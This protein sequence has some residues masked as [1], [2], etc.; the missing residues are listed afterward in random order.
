M[1]VWGDGME[2]IEKLLGKILESQE[3]FEEG[4]KSMQNE[5]SSIKGELADVK[6]EVSGIKV[7]LADVKEEVSGIKVELA[8]VKEE[9]SGI[10]GELADVKEEVS[11]IKGEIVGMKVEI[12]KVGV[13]QEKMQKDIELLAEGHKNIIEIM[14]RKFDDMSKEVN[15]RLDE[16]EAAVTNLGEDVKFIKHKEFQNEESIFKLKESLKIAK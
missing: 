12:T 15:N 6:E 8:D 5:I 11:G 7:E 4:Q 16:V 14:D 10:K 9:V 1:Y 2:R 3:R 13:L